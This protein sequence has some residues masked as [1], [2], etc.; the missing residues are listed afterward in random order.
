MASVFNGGNAE[1]SV[2]LEKRPLFSDA[3]VTGRLSLSSSGTGWIETR[4]NGL[5]L[6][7]LR[8]LGR[9]VGFHVWDGLLDSEGRWTLGSGGATDLDSRIRLTGLVISEPED[10]PI[11]SFLALPVSLQTAIGLLQDQN[12]SIEMP[13]DPNA[14]MNGA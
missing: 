4:V 13:H 11:R 3:R 12:G 9:A 2:A 14:S 5:E 1:A 8:G 7:G 10:G 6:A